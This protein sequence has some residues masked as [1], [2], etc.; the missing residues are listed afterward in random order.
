M[1]TLLF[2]KDGS[3]S[4]LPAIFRP[5]Y[6]LGVF[7]IYLTISVIQVP[8]IRQGRKLAGTEGIFPIS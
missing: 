8:V 6:F 7:S 5:L 3:E 1:H 2:S 4:A